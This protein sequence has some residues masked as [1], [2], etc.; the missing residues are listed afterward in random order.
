MLKIYQKCFVF[1]IKH[2]KIELSQTANLLKGRYENLKITD[3]R[4]RLKD[5]TKLKGIASITIDECFVVHDIKVIEGKDGLFISMP[6]KKTADGQHK[7]IAHPI[8]TETRE[9][10]KEAVLEAYNKALSEKSESA[11]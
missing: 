7:D 10:I 11:V 8:N 9:A 5:E 6:S 3:V 4:I 2:C 1:K